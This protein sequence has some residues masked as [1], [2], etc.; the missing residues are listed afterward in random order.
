[1][2]DERDEVLDRLFA[3]WEVKR[4]QR[5][6]REEHSYVMDLIRALA[7]RPSGLPRQMVLHELRRDREKNS[8]P[9]PAT[10]EEAVQSSYNQYSTD[11]A[12]YKRRGSPPKD[13]LFFAPGG[14]GSG[15]WAT[16]TK[17]ALEWFEER[18]TE[19]EH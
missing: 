6:F 1:M 12:V 16:H 17:A 19:T 2:A 10:F 11:S 4:A 14:K 5:K 15:R 18:L 13:G 7:P 3:E 9:I 8:L